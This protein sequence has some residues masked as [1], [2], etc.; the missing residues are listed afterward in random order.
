MAQ[1]ADIDRLGYTITFTVDDLAKE[2]IDV[3]QSILPDETLAR[4]DTDNASRAGTSLEHL[5]GTDDECDAN[6]AMLTACSRLGWAYANMDF[7]CS[8]QARLVDKAWSI[9]KRRGFSR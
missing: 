4:I 2:F 8:E 6:V 7:G 9:A 1:T 5:C 3:I